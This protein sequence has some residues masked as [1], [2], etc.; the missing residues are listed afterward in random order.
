M[1][2]IHTKWLFLTEN[3]EIV[4]LFIDKGLNVN[5]VDKRANYAVVVLLNQK[6]IMWLF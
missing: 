3:N 4:Q 2:K 5:Q 1:A 6:K